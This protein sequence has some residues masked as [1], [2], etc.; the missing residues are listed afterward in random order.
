MITITALSPECMF[1]AGTQDDKQ[2]LFTLIQ[3][4]DIYTGCSPVRGH[5][6][7]IRAAFTK[8]SVYV[9]APS[10]Q[11]HSYSR[12]AAHPGLS[13]THLMFDATKTL[14]SYSSLVWE[15]FL[16]VLPTPSSLHP[17]CMTMKSYAE[18]C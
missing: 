12:G 7:P 15:S 8:A 18:D 10:R 6:F 5:F 1:L 2:L 11:Y 17:R 4:Q 13:N 3:K 9:A 16:L 14:L